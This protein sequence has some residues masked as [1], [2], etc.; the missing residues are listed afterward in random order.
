M[1]GASGDVVGGEPSG[2]DEH[3]R[4]EQRRARSRPQ[5]CGHDAS[6]QP[7]SEEHQRGASRRAHRDPGELEPLTGDGQHDEPDQPRRQ[8]RHIGPA[9]PQHGGT[10]GE[11]RSEGLDQDRIV[12]LSTPQRQVQADQRGGAGRE[13]TLADHERCRREQHQG[14][15]AEQRGGDEAEAATQGNGSFDADQGAHESQDHEHAVHLGQ[16]VNAH[17]GRQV[18]ED[19]GGVQTGQQGDPGGSQNATRGTSDA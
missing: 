10:E 11:H 19:Q 17:R 12:A 6:Q 16:P 8:D 15:Q 1:D 18:K 9:Q 4:S 13:Q 14:A 3:C 5:Q 7:G 2:Q